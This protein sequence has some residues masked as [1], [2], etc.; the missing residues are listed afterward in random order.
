MFEIKDNGRGIPRDKIELIFDE[1]H[2]DESADNW[3]GTG[4][5]LPIC[6]TICKNMDGFIKYASFP[7]KF[8]IFRLFVPYKIGL[9]EKVKIIK[10]H[11]ILD[12]FKIKNST[13]STDNKEKVSDT[14]YL[15]LSHVC[16]KVLVAEDNP[17]IMKK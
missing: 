4:L 2:T 14:C 9:E 7:N 12:E 5:G 3:D 11:T 10:Y 8:T 15:G 1:K 16:N 6:L 17:N 13:D